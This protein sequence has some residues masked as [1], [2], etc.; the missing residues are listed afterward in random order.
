MVSARLAAACVLRQCMMRPA[1]PGVLL[2]ER[3]RVVTLVSAVRASG[4]ARDDACG[5]APTTL[6]LHLSYAARA[7]ISCVSS[8]AS[9]PAQ[10]RCEVVMSESNELFR[11]ARVVLGAQGRK[12]F[13]DL[14][15]VTPTLGPSI[16]RRDRPSP[17]AYWR[18]PP[19]RTRPSLT[20]TTCY[21]TARV[22]PTLRAS[23]P[24]TRAPVVLDTPPPPLTE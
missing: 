14:R 6:R 20:R 8:R 21:D 7:Y 22:L 4:A 11:I 13:Q 5:A 19:Q 2:R 17:R 15:S 16:C 24:P 12:P 3:E 10:H 18:P 1:P 9:S 23:S